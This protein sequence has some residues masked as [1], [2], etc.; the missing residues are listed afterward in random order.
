MNQKSIE[1]SETFL[2]HI[3]DAQHIINPMYTVS[4]KE[5]KILFHGHWNTDAGPDFKNAIIQIDGHTLKGDIEVHI[6]SK[7]WEYHQHSLNPNYNQVILHIVLEHNSLIPFTINEN[8]DQID[9]V[10][11]VNY[12]DTEIVKLLPLYAN[13]P[14]Q[15]RHKQFC[16]FFSQLRIDTMQ[17]LLEH[18]SLLRLEKKI[19]RCSAEL[20]FYNYDQ[21]CYQSFIEAMGYSKNSSA[22]LELASALPYHLV[23]DFVK[24]MNLLQFQS[25]FLQ[26]AG[27]C[28][29][30]PS[31]VGDNLKNE[32]ESV[33]AT[34]PPISPKKITW[35][36]F[37]VM[38]PNHP[39]IRI[40]QFSSLLYQSSS[41]GL[42]QQIISLFSFY[43]NNFNAHKLKS[44]FYNWIYSN[45]VNN[46]TYQISKPRLD[47]I[48]L[49]TIIP[50]VIH[51]ARSNEF[52][53]LATVA[54]N[55]YSSENGSPSN[56][57][58]RTMS[59]F[60]TAEQAKVIH[61][62]FCYQQGLLNIYHVYCEHHAC[63]ACETTYKEILSKY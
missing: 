36:L 54:Y 44:R 13:K 19:R 60:M 46:L 56:H 20:T 5:V 40:L 61:K 59:N 63:S 25:L 12:L 16:S 27:L 26:Y 6:K 34:L 58:D 37:R 11:I 55:L 32:L 53:A 21:I 62:K 18:H 10:P 47:I 38:P 57:I 14:I 52:S 42:F 39:V 1:I 51:Y 31:F 8:G 33:I 35:N 50:L 29:N 23:M 2:H 4:G 49:N 22:M 9:I 3:W 24:N 43:E 30:I 41:L 45:S 15:D 7:D 28:N 17:V 48:L